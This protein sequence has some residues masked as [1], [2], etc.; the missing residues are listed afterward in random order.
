MIITLKKKH[1]LKSI[2]ALIIL[3][4]FMFLPGIAS[5]PVID[6]DEARFAQASVQMAET[7]D[8]MDIKFQNQNR[9]KKPSGIY[10]LQTISIK[11]LTSGSERKIWVQRVPSV[12]GGIIAV[13]ATYW[14]T[15]TL[16][17]SKAGFIA[18]VMLAL[19]C[20]M[21]FESHVAKTDAVLVGLSAISFGSLISLRQNGTNLSCWALWLSLGLSILI[22]GPIVIIIASLTIISLTIWEKDNKWIRGI[23][24][25]LPITVFIL[26]WVPW[27]ILMWLNTD[28]EFYTA[29]LNNDFGA[30]LFK[31]Q[32]SHS[33]PIGYYFLSIWL[34]LWPTCL[35]I[36]PTIGFA[37]KIL[38]NKRIF[39][40]QISKSVRFCIAAIIPYWFLIEVIP[41]KLMHYALPVFPAICSLSAIAI[42]HPLMKTSFFKLRKINIII[43]LLIGFT[44]T[45]IITAIQL[46][47]IAQD[48]KYVFY[49]IAIGMS[50]IC[51]IIYSSVSMWKVRFSTSLITAS[52]A[53][54]L[55]SFMTYKATLPNLSVLRVSDQIA[56]KFEKNGI[57][58]P[59]HG[60]PPVMSPHF[61]E[62]SLVYNLGQEINISGNIDVEKIN[63]TPKQQVFI[64]DYK[65]NSSLKL[66]KIIISKA[67]KDSFCTKSIPVGMGYNYSKGRP[68]DIKILYNSECNKNNLNKTY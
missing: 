59:R 48:K 47:Y 52:L 57:L 5:L 14:S 46:N 53:S 60:G 6:R 67:K 4:L 20:L 55:L 38:N 37:I 62:P 39:D 26:V 30:K 7:G 63:N 61:K 54:I 3:C 43:F 25:P 51:L 18:A 2:I 23:I 28:G 56:T 11:L 31:S 35:V 42:T 24:K 68:V 13:L 8:L 36:L 66:E 45:L 32:E 64:L 17:N 44:I 58:L 12:I 50:I 1:Q 15:T 19:S 40:A 27:A 33:G 21:V 34:T 49:I 22:K 65:N 29:S 9:Y 41:T 16:L 10:W